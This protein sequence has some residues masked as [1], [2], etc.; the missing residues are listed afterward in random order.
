MWFHSMKYPVGY[1]MPEEV[2]RKHVLANVLI[3]IGI[4]YV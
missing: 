4:G 2:K 3:I 1:Q